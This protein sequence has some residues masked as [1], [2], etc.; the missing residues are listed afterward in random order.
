MGDPL[1]GGTYS[2][3]N[4]GYFPTIDSAFRKLSTDGIAGEVLLELIDE[5]YVA[6]TDSFGFKLDG[7]IP[8]AGPNS[9]VTMKPGEERNVII[10]GSGRYLMRMT[11]TSYFTVDGVSTTG[12]TTLTLHSLYNAQFDRNRG[13]V[14]I[15]NSDHNII[16][17]LTYVGEDIYRYSDGIVVG[18]SYNSPTAP[19]SNLIENNFL[20]KGSGITV[21]GYFAGG[22]VWPDGNIIRGNVIGSEADSLLNWGIQIEKCRNTVVENNIVQNLKVTVT[23]G[24]IL[25]LGINSHWGD[26]DIIR[27]NIVRNIGTETGYTATGI[28]LSGS[29]ESVG[30]SNQVYNNMV[31]DIQST[32]PQSD[33]RVAGI[34]VWYQDDPRIY[35]NTVSLTGTGSNALGSAALYISHNC[36]NIEAVC[37][38]FANTRDESPHWAAAMYTYDATILV[39]DFNDL[40]Y[41]LNANS[42]LVRA[43]SSEYHTLEAWQT[44]GQDV[45]SITEMPHFVEP[46][47]HIDETVA[48][49]LESR[50]APIPGIETDYDGENRSTTTPDIGADEF[51]GIAVGVEGGETL[52]TDVVLAQNY[53]NPFNPSTTIVYRVGSRELVSLRVY[54]LLGREVAMLVNEVKQPGTYTVQWDASSLASGLYFY[55]LEA[56]A[57]VYSKKSVFLK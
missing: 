3:G 38:I 45:T 1:P 11:N 9:R 57:L 37:N 31:Y 7:P 23:V 10:E 36:F 13:L 54:D 29:S 53:P 33:S 48:T 50:G 17:N 34:Q 5:F 52:P 41:V 4:G 20:R 16:K 14:I 18:S 51:N 46:Y 43:G 32:S 21:S 24:E 22:S 39:S 56:G 19:D 35:Y 55:R 8:G 47:L 49:S 6:P 27:N 44:T 15:D 2:L 30:N 25:I 42:C 40:Y 28:L 12:N 26:G